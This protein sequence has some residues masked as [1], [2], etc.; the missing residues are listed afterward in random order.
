MVLQR[1]STEVG[2]VTPRGAGQQPTHSP[3]AD[4]LMGHHGRSPKWLSL[5]LDLKKEVNYFI[6]Q[7]LLAIGT[8]P[9]PRGTVCMVPR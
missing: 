8:K 4:V 7:L 9:T 2:D 1:V 3:A 5:L 6:I